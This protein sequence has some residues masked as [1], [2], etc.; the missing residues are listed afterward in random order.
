V[1]RQRQISPSA[2][3]IA[4]LILTGGAVA[5]LIALVF[6]VYRAG[7][8]GENATEIVYYDSIRSV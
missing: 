2:V 4:T 8:S 5:S 7:Q 6:V 3:K 1:N